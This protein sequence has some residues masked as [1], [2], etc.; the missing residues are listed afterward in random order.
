MQAPVSAAIARDLG[1]NPQGSNQLPDQTAIAD[2]DATLIN[3]AIANSLGV[4]EQSGD[5]W[6]RKLA[7]QLVSSSRTRRHHRAVGKDS[8]FVYECR[9]RH[10]A[11]YQ[12]R[13]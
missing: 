12:G 3:Q 8:Q 5:R 6:F 9:L 11:S 13:N 4:G 2:A 7:D 1:V 10:L